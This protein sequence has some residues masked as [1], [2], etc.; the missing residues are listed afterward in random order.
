VLFRSVTVSVNALTYDQND[1]GIVGGSSSVQVKSTLNG[2]TTLPYAPGIPN[3]K[4]V[5]LAINTT[6]NQS[7]TMWKNYFDYTAGAAGMP[8]ASY[9]TGFLNNE[10]YILINGY[11][12]T[13][14]WD[15]ISV[16]ATNATYSTSIFGASGVIS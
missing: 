6:D 2:I 14:S 12:A 3:T 11:D 10:S 7:R 5:R 4:W 1:R 8:P 16:I 15:D 9:S 13:D